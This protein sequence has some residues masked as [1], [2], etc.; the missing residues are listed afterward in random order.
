M[1]ANQSAINAQFDNTEDQTQFN[2]Q[3]F[4]SK[5]RFRAIE[6]VSSHRSAIEAIAAIEL[7]SA[8]Q[9]TGLI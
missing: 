8:G 9:N 6:G 4:I 2:D 7:H 5:T 3:V 1:R